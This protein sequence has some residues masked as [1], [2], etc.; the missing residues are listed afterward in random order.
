MYF[1]SVFLV[2]YRSI[3]GQRAKD[4]PL[5]QKVCCCDVEKKELLIFY[6]LTFSLLPRLGL[7]VSPIEAF[8][9]A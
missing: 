7:A 2:I 1:P 6:D 3:R 4:F 5:E 9:L 8:L